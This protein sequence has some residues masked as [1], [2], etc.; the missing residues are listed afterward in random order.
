MEKIRKEKDLNFVVQDL[1]YNYID[2][3]SLD[4]VTCTHQVA[5]ADV[6]QTCDTVD[7]NVNGKGLS[8]R[9]WFYDNIGSH[10]ETK[11]TLADFTENDTVFIEEGN[12][13]DF[14]LEVENRTRERKEFDAVMFINGREH[15][16]DPFIVGRDLTLSS[17]SAGDYNYSGTRSGGPLGAYYDG[18]VGNLGEIDFNTQQSFPTDYDVNLI[19]YWKM[20]D[21]NGTHVLDETSNNNDG[22]LNV[23]A[24][25]NALGLWDTN[26]SFFDGVNDFIEIQIMM[27]SVFLQLTN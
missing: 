15:R 25:T 26:A 24:D 18:N 10:I 19:G 8:K 1:N 2:C 23:G 20:N 13:E 5:L 6:N 14:C 9:C 17:G 11:E 12:S 22:N 4:K 7:L 3:D 16:I 27:L 21:N